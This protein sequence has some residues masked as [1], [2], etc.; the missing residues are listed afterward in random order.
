MGARDER[1]VER[2]IDRFLA[3]PPTLLTCL[4]RLPTTVCDYHHGLPLVRADL[5]CRRLIRVIDP[6]LLICLCDTFHPAPDDRFD[7]CAVP[8]R[9]ADGAEP[10]LKNGSVDT[11]IHLGG[12]LPPLFYWLALMSC[13]TPLQMMVPDAETRGYASRDDWIEALTEALRT[14]FRLAAFVNRQ[15]NRAARP[16]S[17]LPTLADSSSVK[18]EDSLEGGYAAIRDRILDCTADLRRG[19]KA[20]PPGFNDPLAVNVSNHTHYAAG[21]RR[22]LC[23]L[24]HYLRCGH[25]AVGPAEHDRIAGQLLD[26]LRIRN[27]FHQTLVHDKGPMV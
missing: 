7:W 22:L 11:H 8:L 27:A 23:G 5:L 18:W 12:A 9:H 20:P 19:G 13:D 16:F 6:D 1:L 25:S 3:Q 14:R 2:A 17:R 10:L 21:E 26:Y 4:N 24:N 15:S